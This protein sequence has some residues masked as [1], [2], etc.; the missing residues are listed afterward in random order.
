METFDEQILTDL[1]SPLAREIDDSPQFA[2]EPAENAF[3]DSAAG[4]SAEDSAYSDDPVRVY[5]REM[6]SVSLLTRQKEVDLARRMERGNLRMRKALSR[7]TV[8]QPMVLGLYEDI[9]QER[10]ALEDVAEVG[11]PDEAAK[12]RARNVAMRRFSRAAALWN[13]VDA[14]QQK[15]DAT[16]SR[17]VRVRAR[18]ASEL[19]RL[20]VKFSQAIREIPFRA[21]QW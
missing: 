19:V 2:E 8:V 15:L 18:L 3:S 21:K 6:G 4:E 16:P 14:L 5:L 9:R 17:L 12:K 1:T 7:S 10:V 20:K 11:G 13:E